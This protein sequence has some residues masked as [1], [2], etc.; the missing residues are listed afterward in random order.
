MGIDDCCGLG[1]FFKRDIDRNLL[2]IQIPDAHHCGRI[3]DPT[4][5]GDAQIAIRQEHFHIGIAEAKAAGQTVH[6]G[7]CYTGRHIGGDPAHI[8]DGFAI[9]GQMPFQ[10]HAGVHLAGCCRQGKTGRL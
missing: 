7:L 5:A 9:L 2:F 4:A 6:I 1:A 3:I 10:R 8:F